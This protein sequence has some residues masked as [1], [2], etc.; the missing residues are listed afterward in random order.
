MKKLYF[1]LTLVSSLLYSQTFETFKIIDNGPSDKRINLV[2]LGDGFTAT[3]QD[4]FISS[5]TDIVN[6][7]FDESPYKEYK[8]YFNVYAI[9]VVS[10]ESGAKHPG[11][12]T[13]VDEPV[14]PV[15][16]PNNYLGTTF[17]TSKVHRCLYGKDFLTTSVLAAN[18]PFFDAAFVIS[19]TDN[20]GGCAATYAYFANNSS[21]NETAVHE[22]GHSFGDLADEYWYPSG[23]APNKTQDSNPA[24]NKWRNWLGTDGVGIYPYDDG[25]PAWFRPHQNCKMRYLGVPYCRV[26]QEAIV[27]R[28]H[29]LQSAID[30]YSPENLN[31][32]GDDDLTFNVNLILPN[33]NTLDF[34]WKLNGNL[35]N[36]TETALSLNTSQLNNGTNELV[37][38][39]TDNSPFVRT[40]NHNTV[41]VNV[42]NWQIEYDGMTVT[43]MHSN[44]TR[45]SIYPNPTTDYMYLKS[46]QKSFN[47]LTFQVVDLSGKS[48]MSRNEKSNDQNLFTLNLK[49]LPI[50]TYL[51]KIYHNGSEIYTQKILKQ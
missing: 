10:E 44:K 43:D 41:H 51:L 12:A 26:C 9:K 32:N 8:N 25:N 28:V 5:A 19:N 34:D 7:I 47:E 38:S 18:T 31:L 20:Y 6:Y 29:T 42:V 50:G 30:S 11:T 46:Y 27:E 24:T 3:Q 2:V 4:D 17:D 49:G 39:V 14:F 15:S 45:F 1:L 21:S 13:D 33:P 23:E 16:N 22:L 36:D 35:I 48:I 37:F 40:D